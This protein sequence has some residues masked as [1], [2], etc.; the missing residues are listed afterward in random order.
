VTAHIGDHVHLVGQPWLD[1]E[2]DAIARQ[3]WDS[4]WYS[5]H[6][7]DGRRYY[8]SADQT[9]QHG[10][11]HREDDVWPAWRGATIAGR[12]TDPTRPTVSWWRTESAHQLACRLGDVWE[13][14]VAI[15]AVV[16]LLV[17][18]VAVIALVT[19]ALW[20]IQPNAATGVGALGLLGLGLSIYLLCTYRA[21]A[22]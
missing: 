20:P 5:G 17:L 15:A 1:L 19:A 11:H 14:L 9:A 12:V 16:A 18:G 2:I 21:P 22:P 8:V 4:A 13:R 10:R 7:R 6:D 3:G